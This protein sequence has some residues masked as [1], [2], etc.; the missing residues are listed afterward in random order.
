MFVEKEA[1]WIAA[2]GK[3]VFAMPTVHVF[4]ND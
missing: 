1:D 4:E 3:M 2:G